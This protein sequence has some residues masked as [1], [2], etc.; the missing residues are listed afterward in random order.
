MGGTY[1]SLA[2]YLAASAADGQGLFALC[3]R[4]GGSWRSA[5]GGLRVLTSAAW[6]ALNLSDEPAVA[7]AACGVVAVLGA[8]AWAIR[9]MPTED[10]AIAGAVVLFA[11]VA[12]ASLPFLVEGRFGIL[13]TSL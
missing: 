2:L 12:L 13:G 3:G 8:G 4:R 1:A 7:L 6:G 5:S 9:R 11:A 10:A